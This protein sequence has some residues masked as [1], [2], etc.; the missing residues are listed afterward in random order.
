[1]RV[2]LFVPDPPASV[3]DVDVGVVRA[4]F[5]VAE[6]IRTLTVIPMVIR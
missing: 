3:A 2:T 6:G 5:G 4:A 1:M